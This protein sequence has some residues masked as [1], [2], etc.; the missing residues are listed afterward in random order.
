MYLVLGG[1]GRVI[2]F[3]NRVEYFAAGIGDGDG[4]SEGYGGLHSDK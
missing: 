3:P 2:V 1:V 4:M